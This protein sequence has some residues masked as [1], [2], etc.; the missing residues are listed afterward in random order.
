MFCQKIKDE[1]F[2]FYKETTEIVNALSYLKWLTTAFGYIVKFY[3]FSVLT[4]SLGPH[5]KSCVTLKQFGWVERGFE[6][7]ITEKIWGANAEYNI[8]IYSLLH[9]CISLSPW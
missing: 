7:L 8:C 3:S 1:Q 9:Q 2:F 5:R 6:D 4:V